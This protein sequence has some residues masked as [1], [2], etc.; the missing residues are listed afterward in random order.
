MATLPLDLDNLLAELGARR[1]FRRKLRTARRLGTSTCRC[2]ELERTEA[3]Y[4]DVLGFDVTRP[5]LSGRAVRVRRRATTII[6]A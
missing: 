4:S 6:S 1:A 5:R 3:F 2:S